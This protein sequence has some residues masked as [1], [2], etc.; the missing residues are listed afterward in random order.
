MIL[1]RVIESQHF[2]SAAAAVCVLF[3]FCI[4]ATHAYVS[5]KVNYTCT[6]CVNFTT[7]I[8]RVHHSSETLLVTFSDVQVCHQRLSSAF[9]LLLI[10]LCSLTLIPTLTLNPTP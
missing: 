10:F 7:G 4:S 8:S 6:L 1:K 2:F 9:D 5:L 3:A